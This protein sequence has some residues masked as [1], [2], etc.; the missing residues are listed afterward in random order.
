MEELRLDQLDPELVLDTQFEVNDGPRWM[1]QHD[2][3]Y[4]KAWAE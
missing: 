4:R 3:I 1:D 2:E